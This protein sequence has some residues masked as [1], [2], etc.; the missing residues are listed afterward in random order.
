[1]LHC[2]S[3]HRSCLFCCFLIAC[4]GQSQSLLFIVLPLGPNPVTTACSLA[5]CF[6]FWGRSQF[7]LSLTVLPLCHIHDTQPPLVHSNPPCTHPQPLS[8]PLTCPWASYRQPWPP[9]VNPNLPWSTPTSCGHPWATLIHLPIPQDVQVSTQPAPL[10]PKH[11]SARPSQYRV[12]WSVISL[13]TSVHSLSPWTLLVSPVA[14]SFIPVLCLQLYPVPVPVHYLTHL[15][16]CPSGF[17]LC[18][19]GTY[20]LAHY[21]LPP[22]SWVPPPL[23]SLC[24]I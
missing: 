16:V 19:S 14:Y 2:C 11:A 8:N 21:V 17:W 22:D 10:I 1:M 5:C 6:A 20:T 4:W 23:C 3:L 18:Q 13:L 15:F 24:S 9:M 12:P 7:L